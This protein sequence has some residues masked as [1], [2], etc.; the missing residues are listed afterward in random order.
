M[1]PTKNTMRSLYNKYRGK[2]AKTMGS[3]G[4]I[5]GYDDSTLIMAVTEGVEGLFSSTQIAESGIP[6]DNIKTHKNNTIGYWYCAE[7][8][9]LNTE[10]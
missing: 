3:T 7:T 10:D 9:I 6:I 2:T 1:I 4:I 8:N 5:C